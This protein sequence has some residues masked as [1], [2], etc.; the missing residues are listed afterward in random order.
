MTVAAWEMLKMHSAESKV[1][2]TFQNLKLSIVSLTPVL[3]VSA[4]ETL[5]S[6][7]KRS[8]SEYCLRG[9]QP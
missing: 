9:M 1:M 8:R 6:E 7:A 4:L 5:D 2:P 3:F